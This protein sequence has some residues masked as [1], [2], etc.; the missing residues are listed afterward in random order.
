MRTTSLP[1]WRADVSKQHPEKASMHDFNKKAAAL[2]YDWA[3]EFT[4]V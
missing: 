2:T 4:S 3:E 1:A